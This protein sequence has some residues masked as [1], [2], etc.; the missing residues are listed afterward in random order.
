[1]KF[2]INLGQN[3]FLVLICIKAEVEK[4]SVVKVQHEFKIVGLLRWNFVSSYIQLLQALADSKKLQ[5]IVV[6]FDFVVF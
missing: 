1:M 3:V 2:I 5:Q 4:G 6:W